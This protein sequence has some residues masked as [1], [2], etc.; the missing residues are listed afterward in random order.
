[1]HSLNNMFNKLITFGCSNTFGVGL[2]DCWPNTEFPS[3]LGW[4]QQLANGVSL[5]L[6]NLSR[7][8]ASNLGILNDIISLIPQR[9]SEKNNKL[10]NRNKNSEHNEK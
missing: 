7:P 4:A 8:G 3:K 10:Y 6:T 1:M 5:P 9:F 2:P